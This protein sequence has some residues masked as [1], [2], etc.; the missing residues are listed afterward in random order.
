M[1]MKIAREPYERVHVNDMC[2]ERASLPFDGATMTIQMFV[3]KRSE[4]QQQQPHD[5]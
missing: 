1:H 2:C 3:A 4:Q 5:R